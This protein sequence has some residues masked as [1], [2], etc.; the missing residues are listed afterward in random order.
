[1]RRREFI[2]L[3]AGATAWS[4]AVR[5]QQSERMKRIGV[6]SGLAADDPEA[7]ARNAALLQ[8]L[9]KL[10]WFVDRNVR[11]DYRWGGA[12]TDRIRRCAAELVALAP[13]VILAT[14]GLTVGT[15]QQR[16]APCQSCSQRLSIRSAA[17]S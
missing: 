11:I 15:L 4:P 8:G 10:G 14:S 13:D 3:L 12:D 6:L 9:G 5:A 16:A 7:Q 1:M 2:G 17:A